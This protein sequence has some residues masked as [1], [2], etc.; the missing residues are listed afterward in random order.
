M[1]DWVPTTTLYLQTTN[2]RKLH[3]Q[4]NCSQTS[5]R[6]A[7]LKH[8]PTSLGKQLLLRSR[9]L[10]VKLQ[11]TEKLFTK[12]V[13][14]RMCLSVDFATFLRT[15]SLQITSA[16]LLLEHALTKSFPRSLRVGVFFE[17]FYNF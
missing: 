1:F 4:S 11:A 5:Y 17:F 9:F 2:K 7:V 3:T 6:K 10:G 14:H 16:Q 13:F 12:N 15:A 8:F